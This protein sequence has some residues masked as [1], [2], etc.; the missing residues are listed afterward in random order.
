MKMDVKIQIYAL[1]NTETSMAIFVQYIAH[2]IARMTKYFVQGQGAELMAV[3]GQTN[4]KTKDTIS[5]EKHQGNLAQDGVQEYAKIT[6]FCVIAGST[7]VMVVLQKK[8]VVRQSR[9]LM[10]C[11]VQERNIPYIMRTKILEKMAGGEVDFCQHLIIVLS[12]VEKILVRLVVRFMK[13][14]S[15]VSQQA[16]V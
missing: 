6:K 7:L 2:K 10:E 11:F 4:A 8:F 5:G 16:I 14:N 9:M 3:M 1:N 12:I 15:V 13:M